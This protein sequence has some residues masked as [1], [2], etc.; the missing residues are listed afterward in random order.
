MFVV[1]LTLLSACQSALPNKRY[2]S[3]DVPAELTENAYL[4]EIVRYLYRWHLE[5]TEVADLISSR[6]MVFWIRRM[7]VP[8]DPGDKSVLAEILLPQVDIRIKIKR[9]DYRIEELDADVKSA[10]FKVTQILRGDLYGRMPQ[11][12]H[13]VKIDMQVLRDYLFRTRAQQDYPGPELVSRMQQALRR[14]AA[15]SGMLATND[16]AGA[17]IVHIA[18]LSPVANECWV[19]WEAGRKLFFFSSDINLADPAVWRHEHLA[20]RIYDLDQQVVVT[21]EEAPG[22]NRFLTRYEVSRAL[23]NCI[24]FGQRLTVQH[25]GGAQFSADAMKRTE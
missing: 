12:A 5:E 2:G 23:F 3:A 16:Y 25:H 14:E 10:D 11:G 9:A 6:N 7:D 21:H 22:S 20:A 15:K 17:K 8:L 4:F 18:P 1:A 24:M 13:A 19:F